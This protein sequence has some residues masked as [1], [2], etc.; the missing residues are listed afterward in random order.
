MRQQ[1]TS[2]RLNFE[3]PEEAKKPLKIQAIRLGISV[4][5]G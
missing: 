5:R 1:Q 4:Q 2:S 3:S